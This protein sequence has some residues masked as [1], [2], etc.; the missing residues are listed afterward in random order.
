MKN[1]S[2]K[3]AGSINILTIRLIARI[4]GTLFALF[5]TLYLSSD[6]AA[7]LR[8][9]QGIPPQPWD[10]FKIAQAISFLFSIVGLILAYWKEGPGGL[11]AFSGMT[12]SLIFMKYNPDANFN[13]TIFILLIP[14]LLYLLYWFL[15][16]NS[17]VKPGKTH[18]K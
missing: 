1:I 12:L 8:P 7:V 4:I 6:L 11:I 9:P 18:R 10:F 2:N 3:T 15:A 17:S 16:R 5:C 14:S 13:F